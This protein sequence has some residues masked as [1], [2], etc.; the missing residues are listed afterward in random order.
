[1]VDGHDDPV[2]LPAIYLGIHVIIYT[3]RFSI[4]WLL[5]SIAKYQPGMVRPLINIYM[6]PISHNQTPL[7]RGIARAA[8]VGCWASLRVGLFV[9]Y[10]YISHYVVDPLSGASQKTTISVLRS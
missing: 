6:N 3:C 8:Q 9:F 2:Y 10:T 7:T 4:L 5:Q 1:M